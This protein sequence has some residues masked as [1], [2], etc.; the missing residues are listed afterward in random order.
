[1]LL[2]MEWA[3]RDKR[4]LIA[5][6]PQ[7]GVPA[8]LFL[9]NLAVLAFSA[10]VGR[11]IP[12]VGLAC[13]LPAQHRA[14]GHWA[15][16]SAR[17]SRDAGLREASRGEQRRAGADRRGDEP[18]P[19]EI[20]LSALRAWPSRRRSISSPLSSSPTARPCSKPRA[21]CC[22]SPCW[23][24]RVLSFFTI[25]FSATCPTDRP[26]AHVHDRRG[27]DRRLR[28]HLFR[29]ARTPARPA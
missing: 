12:D 17:H 9:A 23:W 7:F 28:L 5:S 20:I 19:E 24:R 18:K 4:G 8:G 29:A 1:M 27:Y 11:P 14:G 22:S 16:D 21:I 6:W 15:L 2:S 3:G 25:P 10:Y 13:A 26:Q